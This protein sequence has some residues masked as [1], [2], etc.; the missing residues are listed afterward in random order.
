LIKEFSFQLDPTQSPKHIDF[1]HPERSGPPKDCGGP[2]P[3]VDT[4]T[5]VARGID[6]RFGADSPRGWILHRLPG[7]FD[8]PR[9]PRRGFDANRGRGSSHP[10]IVPG[11]FPPPTR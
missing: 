10:R 4:P 1:F 6:A 5:A 11:H 3:I 2:A 8:S 9:A 7:H